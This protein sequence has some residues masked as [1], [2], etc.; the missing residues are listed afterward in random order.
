MTQ[1]SSCKHTDLFCKCERNKFGE[2]IHLWIVNGNTLMVFGWACH[3]EGKE[4]R[5]ELGKIMKGVTFK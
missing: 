3:R 1:P 4:G 2:H 5:K